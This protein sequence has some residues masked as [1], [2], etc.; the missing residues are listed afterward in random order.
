MPDEETQ[1][2][3]ETTQSAEDD[4]EY[5]AHDDDITSA[6]FSSPIQVDDEEDEEEEGDEEDEEEDGEEDE[7]ED[8]EEEED[9]EGEEDDEGKASEIKGEGKEK[10][11]DTADD[12]LLGPDD[13]RLEKLQVNLKVNGQELGPHPIKKVVEMAQK[14]I[15]AD[16]KFRNAS[17]QAQLAST[18][19]KAAKQDPLGTAYHLLADEI[20]EDQ[21]YTSV[22]KMAEDLV[23][24]ELE[25]QS[26]PQAEQELRRKESALDRKE[27]ELENAK[28]RENLQKQQDAA[29]RLVQDIVDAAKQEKLLQGEGDP[30]LPVNFEV[31]KGIAEVYDAAADQGSPISVSEAVV[32]FKERLSERAVSYLQALSEDERQRLGL[33]QPAANGKQKLRMKA[34]KPKT[35]TRKAKSKRKRKEAPRFFNSFEEAF[36][37]R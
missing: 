35:S 31:L 4:E 21:A 33:A 29:A 27:R 32:R 9:E 30:G 22:I 3:E 34:S 20:G 36:K 13:E 6:D 1:E 24:R 12:S 28:K 15:A 14:G 8:E 37:H 2:V 17:K 11:D 16:E 18:I 5:E 7:D 10:K 26:L 25:F 23:G 19:I